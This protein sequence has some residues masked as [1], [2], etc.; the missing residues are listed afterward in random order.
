MG[1]SSQDLVFWGNGQKNSGH[2]GMPAGYS[3][4]ACDWMS[5][6]EII[7]DTCPRYGTRIQEERIP[8]NMINGRIRRDVYPLSSN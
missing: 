3:E 7:F 1:I 6:K 4:H 5:C 8:V 2:I